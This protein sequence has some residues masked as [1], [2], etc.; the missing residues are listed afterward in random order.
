MTLRPASSTRPV[1]FAAS[2]SGDS[3]AVLQGD[4]YRA[5]DGVDESFTAQMIVSAS[6]IAPDIEGL[7][8]LWVQGVGCGTAI[9]HF[10]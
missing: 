4:F 9:V 5:G 7:Q 8:N 10:R 2:R 1:A 3:T 6:D